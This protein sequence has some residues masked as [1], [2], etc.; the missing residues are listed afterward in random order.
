MEHHKLPSQHLLFG[1]YLTKIGRLNDGSL[2]VVHGSFLF[3][4]TEKV[5]KCFKSWTPSD[6]FFLNPQ[7]V[8][9]D[10]KGGEGDIFFYL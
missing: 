3:P 6:K 4:S 10:T 1:H 8:L 7:R 9:N 5:N 2:L